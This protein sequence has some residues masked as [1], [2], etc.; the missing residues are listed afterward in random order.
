MKFRPATELIERLS[1]LEQGYICREVLI[2]LVW[3]LERTYRYSRAQIGVALIELVSAAEL[4]IEIA[5]DLSFIVELYVNEGF[6]FA[7]LLV[8]AAT[9]RAGARELVT[10][11]L[12][13]ARLP[14]VR[15]IGE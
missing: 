15:M 14:D 3:V 5:D 4:V 13:A 6:D 12:R 1:V 8:I 7:D 11:D 10:F 2:E 9:R